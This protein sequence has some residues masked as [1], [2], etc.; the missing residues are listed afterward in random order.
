MRVRFDIFPAVAVCTG[1][2]RLSRLSTLSVRT[3]GCG[4]FT[5]LGCCTGMH[6]AVNF[7]S[8]ATSALAEPA[9][10]LPWVHE[11][12][13]VPKP[14][15]PKAEWMDSALGYSQLAQREWHLSISSEC[16]QRVTATILMLLV[17]V[18]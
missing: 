13:C 16:L 7:K 5:N 1:W 6:I 14:Q 3:H 9:V 2:S 8:T 15:I 17:T 18:P 4:A 11:A 10:E 12:N